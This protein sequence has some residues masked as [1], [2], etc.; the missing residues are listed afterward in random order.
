M[1]LIARVD[2]SDWLVD[3]GFGGSGP[4]LP[5][6][7]TNEPQDQFGWSYRTVRE[8]GEYVLQWRR[9]AGWRDLY[10]F[11]PEPRFA[12][13]FEVA[14]WYTSTH[15]ESRFVI[16]LTVQS[17]QLEVRHLLN[18]LDYARVR[19]DGHETR[20]LGRNELVG[21]IAETFDLAL[22]AEARFRA[23]DGHT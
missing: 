1:V 8:G 5:V 17:A 10:A 18:N 11:S 16:T 12:A 14:N 9:P 15:P 20:Q 7:L 19:P 21:F 2:G 6:A 13:D 4:L 22:P 3:V 23:L